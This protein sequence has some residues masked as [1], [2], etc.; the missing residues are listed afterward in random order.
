MIIIMSQ[1][2]LRETACFSPNKPVQ[3]SGGLQ[4]SFV[5]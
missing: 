5:A 1:A 2:L 3:V 4:Q